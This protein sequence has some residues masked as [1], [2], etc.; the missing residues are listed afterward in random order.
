MSRAGQI[1]VN[2]TTMVEDG[3]LGSAIIPPEAEQPI[4]LRNPNIG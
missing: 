2:Q 4:N 3:A 1:S